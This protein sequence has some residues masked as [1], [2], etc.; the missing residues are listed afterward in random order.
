VRGLEGFEV[1]AA[2]LEGS[3]AGLFDIVDRWIVSGAVGSSRVAGVGCSGEES[4][5]GK[6][7]YVFYCGND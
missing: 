5:S 4:F 7:V 1:L 3:V 2:G 6:H